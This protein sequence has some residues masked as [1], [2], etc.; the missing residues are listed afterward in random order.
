[1]IPGGMRLRFWVGVG[2]SAA[3]VFF[4]LRLVDLAAIGAALADVRAAPLSLAVLA[5]LLTLV[6]KA[7]RWHYLMESIRPVDVRYLWSA[8]SIGAMVDMV[9]PARTGDVV[10]AWMVGRKANVS[11]M[12]SLATIVVEKVL[13]VFV[14]LMISVPLLA[15]V[16][17]PGEDAALTRGFRTGIYAGAIACFV[18]VAALFLF[19]SR[20]LRSSTLVHR[21]LPFLPDRLRSRIVDV[22][23]NF[24]AGMQTIK[25]GRHLFATLALSLVLWTTYALSNYLVL[26][27]F[28]L[29]LPVYASFLFLIFQALGVTLPSS[30]GFIGTY[31]AAVVVGFALFG[32]SQ[33]MAFGVAIV[34]HAAFFFPFIVLG[35]F[36]LW[37][38]NLSL[39]SLSSLDAAPA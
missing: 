2:L 4:M 17:F 35:F 15:F 19:R 16:T 39:R 26:A 18:L 37:R 28:S 12:S 32:V 33:D 38:E 6:L 25:T 10:R 36:L 8:T 14:I 3:L 30:P 20:E 5:L 34:M 29:Q 9:L 1:M 11:K 21:A 7:W 23:D 27:A 22:V 13:D 24:G 31:H